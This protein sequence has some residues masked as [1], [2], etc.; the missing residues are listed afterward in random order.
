MS[1]APPE[2]AARYA[3]ALARLYSRARAARW[4]LGA[5]ILAEAAARGASKSGA[6]ETDRVEAYLDALHAEDLALALA[7]KGGNSR[8]WEHF[9]SSLRPPLYAAARAIAGDE[10]R[11]RELADSIWADLYGLEVRDGTRR[12]LLEYFHGRSS[13][14]TWMRAILAQRHIDYV[15]TQQRTQPLDDD[16]EDR[17]IDPN[18]NHDQ[19][20]G[21]ERARYV[22][23]LSIAL[24]LALKTLAPQDRMR[25]AY[26]YRHELSLKEIG[27]LMGEH[28]SS[29]SRK[30]ARTRDQ[31]KS[32][33]ERRLR[34]IDLLSQDQIRLCYDFAAGDLQFDLARALPDNQ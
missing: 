2:F 29:V 24:D 1:D 23:M 11:G 6:V 26:Y 16:V 10:M 33:I 20:A 15:R 34:D 14:L 17:R 5:D 27:R 12:S 22:Q 4:N 18:S 28:E 32:E 9:I 25:M 21:P 31:L 30:L 8:A 7:C 13:I 3:P 19:A